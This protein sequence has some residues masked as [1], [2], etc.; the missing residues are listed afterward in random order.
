VEEAKRKPRSAA[1]PSAVEVE[2][3][4]VSSHFELLK[5]TSTLADSRPYH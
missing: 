1:L 5:R 4:N 2:N 3:G